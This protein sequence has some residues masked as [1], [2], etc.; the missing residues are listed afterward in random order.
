[1]KKFLIPLL[2]LAALTVSCKKDNNGLA[3]DAYKLSVG[4][5]SDITMNGATLHGRFEAGKNCK[6]AEHGIQ[7]V[8][9]IDGNTRMINIPVAETG[10]FS[11]TLDNLSPGERYGYCAYAI[12]N[13]NLMT[14]AGSPDDVMEFRTFSYTGWQLYQNNAV[15]LG[16]GVKWCDR[17]LGAGASNLPGAYLAWGE[18]EPKEVYSKGNYSLPALVDDLDYWDWSKPHIKKEF[19]AAYNILGGTWRM[20][21]A[22]DFQSLIDNCTHGFDSDGNITFYGKGDYNGNSIFLPAAGLKDET[23]YTYL[24]NGA[25]WSSNLTSQMSSG[26]IPGWKES[27]FNLDLYFDKDNP[28]E[29]NKLRLGMGYIHKFCEI[30]YGRP[31]RPVCD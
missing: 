14:T 19:D 30:W 27:I 13:D 10:D 5:V 24:G 17:N 21:T 1:M 16:T 8:G 7:I 28:D 18:I 20:P 9:F 23:S 26:E 11:C 31:I 4:G 12:I 15:D 25:Y 22:D 29:P 3:P 6:N 2:A